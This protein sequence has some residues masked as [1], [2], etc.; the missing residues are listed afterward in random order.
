MI[1][2]VLMLMRV[3]AILLIY[4]SLVSSSA[5][6]A[7][8]SQK[9][10]AP[11]EILIGDILTQD[12]RLSYGY[13]VLQK[14]QRRVRYDYPQK[15]RSSS[16]LI[17][18]SYALLTR[19]G[20]ALARF[21]DNIYFGMGNDTRFGLI[22]VL[23]GSVKQVIISQDVPRGGT[24][25]IID[26]SRRARVIYDG[27]RWAVGR[28]GDDMGVTDLDGDGVYEIT[29]PI[30]DFY[31]LQDKMSMAQ[32]PLPEIVFKYDPRTREYLPANPLFQDYLFKGIT[33]PADISATDELNHRSLVLRSTLTFIYA[34]KRQEGWEYFDHYY[35]LKDES[36][37]RR[38]VKSILARQP[39]YK[40]IYNHRRKY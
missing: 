3:I 31:D 30:T 39:V 6:P 19:K 11:K 36:E 18:V 9:G 33:S 5:I 15:A 26:L 17:D 7:L 20:R 21:D 4:V 14:R 27:P 22:S 10:I 35:K 12:N 34:G 40:F 1:D 25:W 37:I 38:R 32:I 2:A 8:Q 24:Q 13:Y 16:S 23:G 28:E 29:V